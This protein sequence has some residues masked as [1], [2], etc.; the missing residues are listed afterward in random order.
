MLRSKGKFLSTNGE[1]LL[2][3]FLFN[4]PIHAASPACMK[5][6]TE[7]H[8]ERG[9]SIVT[10][11]SIF[12]CLFLLLSGF[13]KFPGTSSSCSEFCVWFRI[14]R[15]V[16]LTVGFSLSFQGRRVA[17]LLSTVCCMCLIINLLIFCF[18]RYSL[19]TF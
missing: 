4:G 9:G 2:E 15:F 13:S 10:V 5:T 19:F 6:W 16:T 14:E 7:T 11:I 12:S 1:L 17:M 3:L 8:W 18:M